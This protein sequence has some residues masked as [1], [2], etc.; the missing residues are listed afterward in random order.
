MSND[1]TNP[2]AEQR[3]I[4][5]ALHLPEETAKFIRDVAASA[6]VDP[7]S[8]AS[9]LLSLALGRERRAKQLTHMPSSESQPAELSAE[10]PQHDWL[11]RTV[12]CAREIRAHLEGVVTKVEPD[13]RGT[14]LRH[15]AW[16]AEQLQSGKIQDVFKA[17][18]WLGYLQA[19]LVFRE[20]STLSD[21]IERVRRSAYA[22]NP[23]QEPAGP[24]D[25]ALPAE[26]TP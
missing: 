4:A 22:E 18:R 3:L 7:D 2:T 13:S 19:G 1:E 14:S 10:D 25:E 5:L 20:L 12:E 24:H 11:Q 26:G 6:G 21:E 16:M 9:V 8:T 17:S 15:L 23:C